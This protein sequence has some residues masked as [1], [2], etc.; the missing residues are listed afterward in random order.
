M[1]PKPHNL[2][3]TVVLE[4]TIEAA[5]EVAK[6]V[7]VNS[8][9]TQRGIVACLVRSTLAHYDHIPKESLTLG[10]AA[11]HSVTVHCSYNIPYLC[12]QMPLLHRNVAHFH[13]VKGTIF[14]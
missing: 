8:N 5:K 6:K 3:T 1:L 12:R 9:N 14:V 2:L 13:C 11:E 10:K 7:I 4:F